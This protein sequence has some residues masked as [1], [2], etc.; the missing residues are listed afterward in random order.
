MGVTDYLR[1]FRRYWWV[2]LAFTVIGAV[3]GYG[4][5]V[6]NWSIIDFTPKYQSTATLFVATQTGTTTAE[7]YQNDTFSQQR[8]YSYVAL[9]TSEQVATRAVAELQAQISPRE[10]QGKI[11]ATPINKTVML[12]VSVTD[13]SPARAQDYAAAVSDQLVAVVAELETSRR[14]GTPSAAAVV[15]DDAS[16]PTAPV[17]LKLWLRIALG[18]AGGFV[19]GLLAA[20][21]V[22]VLDQRLRGRNGLESATGSLVIATLPKDPVRPNAAVVDLAGD[23]LYAERIRELRTNLRFAI[24]P[25]GA[26]RPRIIAVTSPS[27]GDGRTTTAIDLAAALAESGRSVILVDGDMRHPNLVDRLALADAA[28]VKS[29]QHGLSTLLL[30]EDALNDAVIPQI[31]VSGHSIALL[32]GGPRPPRPGELWATDRAAKLI[33]Q[34]GQGYDYVVVDTPPL[35]SYTDGANVGALADG[36]ILL[37]RIGGTTANS[38]RRAVQ[39]LQSAHVA[40]LGT[41]ATFEP[42][43]RLV[44]RTHSRQR[45]RTA[46]EE[47]GAEGTKGGGAPVA[48]R[49]PVRAG[50]RGGSPESELPDE[51]P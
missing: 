4:S 37:A 26:G 11:T 22:G 46:A 50:S 21:L 14:G 16:Y 47:R 43:S 45:V 40:L 48:D 19:V 3:V 25:D 31:D 1:I 17:N 13:S 51:R 23:S 8:A 7:A 18:A 2:V 24:P 27:E 28:R 15:V 29:V 10:L 42:V 33:A 20:L 35:D 44:A 32:P 34:L 9:A 30:G 39:T 5:W 12:N 49:R 6:I 38:L 36:V 41:V